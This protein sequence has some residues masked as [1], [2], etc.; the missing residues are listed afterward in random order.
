MVAELEKQVADARK[1]V[2]NQETNIRH[3]RGQLDQQREKLKALKPVLTHTESEISKYLIALYKYSR[4]GSVRLVATAETL[5]E[6]QRSIKYIDIV[7]EKDC[8]K[9]CVLTKQASDCHD[10]IIETEMSIDATKRSLEEK[11]SRL[12]LF[13]RS[14]D[15]KVLLLMKIHEEKEYY[16][17]S[18]DEIETA[19]ADLK[20]APNSIEDKNVYDIDPSLG[21]EA[22]KGTLPMPIRGK[23]INARGK[24]GSAAGGTKGVVIQADVD[25]VVRAVFKGKVVYSGQLKGYGEVIILDHGK[26]F[27]SVSAHLSKREK[28]KGDQVR[29][30]DILGWVEQNGS[31]KGASVYFE[32]RKADK[33][34]DPRVWLKAD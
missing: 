32:V 30:G 18:V 33:K 12:A 6:L 10:D 3:V 14:L 7:T 1:E 8:L 28:A 16:E 27:F 31:K 5:N 4:Q 2:E 15:V 25:S 9:L 24:T 34:L 17:T 21:F 13:E 23:M 20:H 11:T 26:R 19:V 29:G 22:C